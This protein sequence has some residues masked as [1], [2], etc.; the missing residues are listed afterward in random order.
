MGETGE[1][2]RSGTDS[3]EPS[4]TSA[5]EV[6]G[7]SRHQRSDTS[8]ALTHEEARHEDQPT[9]APHNN[10]FTLE[11]VALPLPADWES[12]RLEARRIMVRCLARQGLA[13]REAEQIRKVA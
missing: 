13:R 9:H 11:I 3:R 1:S 6:A 4:S 10:G 2:P 7:S 8:E 5:V 12:R